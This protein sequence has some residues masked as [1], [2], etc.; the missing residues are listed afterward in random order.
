MDDKPPRTAYARPLRRNR[1]FLAFLLIIVACYSLWRIR[2]FAAEQYQRPWSLE[3][4]RKAGGSTVVQKPVGA[5]SKLVPLEAH[6]MSKC[7]DA[8]VR[9]FLDA[10]RS[11]VVRCSWDTMLMRG[12]G[13]P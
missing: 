9:P 2:P 13:L 6:I 11:V 3:S 4:A 7:P 1:P 12:A 10:A 5:K 8:K